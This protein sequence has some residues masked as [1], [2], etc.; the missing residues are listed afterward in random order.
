MGKLSSLVRFELSRLLRFP[1]LE[2]IVV[3]AVF[4]SFTAYMS[5][6]LMGTYTDK[7]GGSFIYLIVLDGLRRTFY[8]MINYLFISFIYATLTSSIA[9]AISS[10]LMKN[11]LSFPYRRSE[12]F[13]VESSVT[14]MVPFIIYLTAHLLPFPFFYPYPV[15]IGFGWL[16]WFLTVFL[17]FL[18]IFS[19]CL[20]ISLAF[21][22]PIPSFISSVSILYAM[23]FIT[24][25]LRRNPLVNFIPPYCFINSILGH[26]HV[27]HLIPSSLLAIALIAICYIYFTRWLEL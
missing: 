25:G 6:Y 24:A 3:L 8:A 16:K 15:Q 18:Y 26:A 14:F 1:V 7:T 10:G 12:V 4:N 19:I 17:S 2:V 21:K 22:T 20:T 27:Y 11:L 9:H 23:S 13:I 5:F